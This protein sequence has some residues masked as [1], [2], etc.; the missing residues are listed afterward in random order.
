MGGL[1]DL[2]SSAFGG[3]VHAHEFAR[4]MVVGHTH[5]IPERR[6]DA[7]LTTG[8]SQQSYVRL[9]PSF[10]LTA[11]SRR[12]SREGSA[13]KRRLSWDADSQKKHETAFH[14]MGAILRHICG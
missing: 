3:A 4:Q 11:A 6:G 7:R 13:L 8:L 12:W 1:I 10:V 5:G 14:D 9:D 2:V